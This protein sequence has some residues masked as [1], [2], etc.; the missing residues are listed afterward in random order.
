MGDNDTLVTIAGTVGELKNACAATDKKIDHL[1]VVTE[2]IQKNGSLF[3][4]EK[5]AAAE[6]KKKLTFKEISHMVVVGLVALQ[7]LLALAGKVT[8]DASTVERL[9]SLL[10]GV[11]SP[12]VGQVVNK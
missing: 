3:S 11:S 9:I 12:T 8:I 2:D 1:T 4:R 10:T 6:A 5:W 7:F